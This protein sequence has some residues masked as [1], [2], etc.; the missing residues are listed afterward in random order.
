MGTLRDSVS[1][2]GFTP[3]QSP[4]FFALKNT[5]R[6]L[7]RTWFTDAGAAPAFSSSWRWSST[8]AAVRWRTGTPPTDIEMT[9]FRSRLS[10]RS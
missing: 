10:S 2:I 8:L 7:A 3:T 1:V 5:V 4:A 6:S 9:F